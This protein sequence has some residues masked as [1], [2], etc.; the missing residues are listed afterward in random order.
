MV[1][2]QRIYK[3]FFEY[4]IW[5]LLG[6]EK[7]A[8]KLLTGNAWLFYGKSSFAYQVSTSY[9]RNFRVLEVCVTQVH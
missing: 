1:D 6:H 9:F 3:E 2:R 4:G 8:D 7:I 5:E